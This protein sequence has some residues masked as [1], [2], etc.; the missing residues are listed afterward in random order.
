MFT[1]YPFGYTV[2]GTSKTVGG[3]FGRVGLP[4]GVSV[5]QVKFKTCVDDE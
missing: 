3:V 5:D 4:S 1:A 2:E